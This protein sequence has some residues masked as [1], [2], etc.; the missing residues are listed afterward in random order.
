MSTIDRERCDTLVLAALESSARTG[1][2]IL[3]HL[4]RTARR[5]ARPS[6]RQLWTSLHRLERNRLLRRV[7]GDRR[8]FRLTDTGLR[9]VQARVAAARAYSAALEMVAAS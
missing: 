2:E 1:E 4:A 8:R 5:T 3:D 6:V 9:V 7:V